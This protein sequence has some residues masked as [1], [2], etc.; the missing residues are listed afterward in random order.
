MS[1]E[2]LKNFQNS[3]ACDEFLQGLPDNDVQTSLVSGA[4][5]QGLSL[6]DAADN[7][8]PSSS[9]PSSRFLS[10]QWTSGYRFEEDLQGRVTLTALA[11][12][13]TGD[14][15][16]ESWRNAVYSALGNFLPSGCEDLREKWPPPL[17][18]F[19]TAWAWVDS[20]NLEGQPG[21]QQVGATAGNDSGRRAVV[22]QFRRWNGY[23]GATPAREEALAES[24][25]AR[26]SWERTVAEVM[27][28]V[29]AW[30][31][32]RWDIQ[33]APRYFAPEEEEGEEEDPE[34]EQ[35]VK[36]FLEQSLPQR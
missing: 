26:E 1:A 17:M 7:D 33:L 20:S 35:K 29:T 13:Y 25:L 6:D 34:Y 14:P 21:Q 2:S 36:E 10:F 3:P 4:S 24:P 23:S 32:E 9:A 15:V 18:H 27:P 19:W 28:P 31:Q 5:L 11:M 30:E 8:A 12:P 16:P 22:C